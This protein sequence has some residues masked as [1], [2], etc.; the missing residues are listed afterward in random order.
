[1]KGDVT[2]PADWEAVARRDLATALTMETLGNASMVC[3][4]S[5][6]AVEKAIKGWLVGQGWPLVKTHDLKRLGA[7]VT[8]RGIDLTPYQADMLRM[9]RLY[10]TDRYVDDSGEPEATATEAGALRTTAEKVVNCCFRRP[11]RLRNKGLE[12]VPGKVNK[13]TVAVA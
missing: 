7:E 10:L 12:R 13:R 1:M 6:Q 2:N 11:L 4:L 3:F 9:S 8:L 5:Q